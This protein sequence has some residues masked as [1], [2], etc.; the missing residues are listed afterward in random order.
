MG[1]DGNRFHTHMN[2]EG[3]YQY[4]ST[5]ISAIHSET[6]A[7]DFWP[8]LFLYYKTFSKTFMST[9][10]LSITSYVNLQFKCS[11]NI[12]KEWVKIWNI[13]KCSL[14]NGKEN[15]WSVNTL[16]IK[17]FRGIIDLSI[18]LYFTNSWACTVLFLPLRI[19]DS[20]TLLLLPYI[21]FIFMK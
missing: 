19:R 8:S 11:G 3:K 16:Y 20:S 13:L 21:I 17:F 15:C 14:N 2:S 6:A 1:L 12:P 7:Q 5:C 18:V 4:A 10:R 9:L